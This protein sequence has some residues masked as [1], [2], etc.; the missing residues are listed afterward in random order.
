MKGNA[1]KGRIVFLI[2]LLL[3]GCAS[4]KD[5]RTLDNE[6]DKLYSQINTLRK[7]IDFAKNDL[8]D[9]RAENQKV[10]T[11][12]SLGSKIFNPRSKP[13]R[14]MWKSIRNFSRGLQKR[15]TVSGRRWKAG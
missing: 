11:D 8:S 9:L 15:R 5:V 3:L 6:M 10:K 13:S 12:L 7:E 2:G 14:Q 4:T 1:M